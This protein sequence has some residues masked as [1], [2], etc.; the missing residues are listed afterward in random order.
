MN[1]RLLIGLDRFFH[2]PYRI[3]RFLSSRAKVSGGFEENPV[4]IIK[5]MGMG[6]ITLLSSVCDEL[7]ID[8]DRIILITFESQREVCELLGFPRVWYVRTSF[9]FFISDCWKL[10]WKVHQL[11]PSRIIDFERCSNS[12]GILRSML[13]FG[14]R[15][16]I[17]CFEN[18]DK[19]DSRGRLKAHSANQ[20]TLA[21][22]FKRGIQ[23]LPTKTPFQDKQIV[24]I[25]NHKI[26]INCNASNYFLARRYPAEGFI[27]L[28][29]QLYMADPL[30]EFHFTGSK[31]EFDYIDG[32]VQPLVSKNIRAK[33]FSGHW[34][35]HQLCEALSDCR[36]FITCDS[37][38]LHLA[39]TLGVTTF[40]IWGPTQ[41]GQF[42]Y[43]N[44]PFLKNF[45]LERSCAP[46]LSHPYSP[47]AIACEG[48]ILCIRN[49]SS[50]VLFQRVNDLLSENEQT[51]KVTR[52]PGMVLKTKRT[53]QHQSH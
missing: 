31:N 22:L 19:D 26:L 10:I 44:L 20:I 2:F 11:Q 29:E 41:P 16:V 46:C 40:A 13:A 8:R 28:V 17:C 36:M 38:P 3:L 25:K 21:S 4:L 45:S 30:L 39:V 1:V 47:T 34:N 24:K 48:K 12:V 23:M 52:L 9:P 33:N 32:I 6:S 15:A 49:I 14:T 53:L 5:F 37:G 42:G 18:S 27:Y 50:Q 35:L 51:R 7:Q 43:E